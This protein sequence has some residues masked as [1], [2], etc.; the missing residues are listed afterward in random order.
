[1]LLQDIVDIVY[2]YEGAIERRVQHLT[3]MGLVEDLLV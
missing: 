2:I 3:H 1:M